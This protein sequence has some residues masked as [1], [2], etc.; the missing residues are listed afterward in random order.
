M[1]N[2]NI[3]YVLLLALLGISGACTRILDKKDLGAVNE[4]DV[5][6]DTKL[7]TAY[8]NRIYA[9]CLPGWTTEYAGYSEEANGGGSYMY[10]QLTENSVDYWPYDDIREINIL[11]DNIDKGTLNESSKKVMKGE[12]WFF[13]AWLYFELVKR[14]GGVPLILK[15]QVVTDDL[16]VKRAKTSECIKQILTDLDS[17]INNLPVISAG[18]GSNDGHVHKGA[19]MA[20]KGRVLLYYASPQFDPNQSGAARWNDAYDANKSAM[21]FLT[22]QGFG[23]YQN[24]SDIWFKEM[25]KEV[26][27]AKRYIYNPAN[28]ASW[29]NWAASTRP[30][31]VSQGSTGGNRPTWDMVQ[32]FPMK[33]GFSI[34]SA[35]SAYTYDAARFWENRDPRFN[36][37]IVYNTASWGIGMAGPTP[38]R[39]QFTFVGAEQN[40]PTITGFYM[41]KAV[42]TTQSAIQAYNSG[43]DW[44]EMRYAEVM[45]NYAE[46]ANETGRTEEAYT[47]LKALRVRAGIDKGSNSMYGLQVGMTQEQMR[48]AIELERQIEFAYEGKRFWDLR[49][50]RLFESRLNGKKRVGLKTTLKAGV[51]KAA[52]TKLSQQ[53]L[54]ANYGNYFDQQTVILDTQF[55][56][57]WKLEYYF[58]AIPTR[59]IELNGNLEQTKGWSGG[60]FDPLL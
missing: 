40:N 29:N 19:A 60:T 39:L 38:G 44:I 11:L 10:G 55:P 32:I 34:G 7:A 56:I 35:N 20:V 25:N 15:S 46:A 30:L 13:R 5:W 14:Y 49:R 42:D 16:L 4:N 2:N 12:S 28:S 22:A 51:T 53:E 54:Q 18:G 31:D 45:L 21:E 36:Q 9:R 41:R 37:T 8:V 17:A 52:V 26:V 43:T 48:E 23:L 33:D 27:F 57:A 47:Q 59:H 24:F 58:F 3:L 50:S 1:K 6:K